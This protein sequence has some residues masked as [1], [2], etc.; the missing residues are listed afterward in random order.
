MA[1]GKMLMLTGWQSRKKP[2]GWV[3]SAQQSHVEVKKR[4][5]VLLLHHGCFTLSAPVFPSSSNP[6]L[7]DSKELG[8]FNHTL[9]H[10]FPEAREPHSYPTVQ[11]LSELEL[12]SVRTLP[13]PVRCKVRLQR[14]N[15]QCRP[16]WTDAGCLSTCAGEGELEYSGCWIRYH[17]PK[18]GGRS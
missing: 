18:L 9:A 3:N 12:S 11:R 6:S 10:S 14:E 13:V 17:S 16:M 8:F 1:F 4:G 5:H 7:Q 15:S 2:V